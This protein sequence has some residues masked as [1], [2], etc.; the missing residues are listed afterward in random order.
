MTDSSLMCVTCSTV[1]KPRRA[2][3]GYR[4]CNSCSD[5]IR[6]AIG[7]IP[8]QYVALTE[9][10]ALLPQMFE[11]GRRG[12]GFG[13]RSPARDIVIAVTDWRTTWTEDDRLHNPLSVLRSWASMVRDEVSEQPPDHVT[14]YTEAALL[15]RRL[16]HVTR[17][18]WVDDMWRE[19]RECRD[20]LRTIAGEPRPVPIGRCPNTP[21]GQNE[22]CGAPL[23]APAHGDTITCRG[24]GEQW[25]RS[26]W[27]LLGKQIGVVA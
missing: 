22:E 8:G 24:C 27:Q 9:V 13:S 16:D 4:T 25:P 19:L 2:T 12:P 3:P 20:Q 14:I 11:D 26:R 5:R 15:V 7:E 23:Y 6:E 17:Q 1:K 21:E 18:E 10:E